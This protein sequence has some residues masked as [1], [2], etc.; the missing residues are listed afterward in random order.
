MRDLS[1]TTASESWPLGKVQKF[2]RIAGTPGMWSERRRIIRRDRRGEECEDHGIQTHLEATAGWLTRAQDVTGE[3]R[4]VSAA[5]DLRLGWLPS[6]PETT[7]YIAT[8]FFDYAAFSG[9]ESFRTRAFEL[10]DWECRIQFE[11]GSVR[12]G[13]RPVGV[14]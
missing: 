6:Y 9:D 2:G 12:G 5:F 10:V 13:L 1:T 3:G 7:G 4:G 11:D 8:S 14:L